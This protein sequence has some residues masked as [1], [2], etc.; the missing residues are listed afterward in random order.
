MR[1]DVHGLFNGYGGWSTDARNGLRALAGVHDGRAVAWDERPWTDGPPSICVP[2]GLPD[3]AADV[4]LLVAPPDCM[5]VLMGRVRIAFYVRETAVVPAGHL[6]TLREADELCTPP[7]WGRDVLIANGLCSARLKGTPEGVDAA[8]FRPGASTGGAFRFL[9]VGKWEARKSVKDLLHVWADTFGSHAGA[10][11]IPHA[12]KSYLPGF[13]SEGAVAALD[14]P[15]LR[16]DPPQS[17]VW[18]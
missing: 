7:D 3:R 2:T 8:P 10:E 6:Q 13:A 17:S 15:R 1:I 4:A 9:F 12:F 18:G 11:L 14:L 5:H 16:A